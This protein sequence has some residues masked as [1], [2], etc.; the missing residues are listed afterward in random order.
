LATAKLDGMLRGLPFEPAELAWVR[1]R[2]APLVGIESTSSGEREESFTA[3]QRFVEAL[4]GS[5]GA[6]LVFEDLHW[7]DPALLAFLER[8]AGSVTDVPMLLVCSARP[9]LADLHPGWSSDLDNATI[10][11][12][13]PLSAQ[14]TASLVGRLLG[15]S[16]L[17]SDVQ[18]QIVERA[19]NPLYAEELIRMLRDRDLLMERGKSWKLAEGA[20]ILSP[21]ACRGSSRP[22]STL[23]PPITS[24]S[25][26][27]PP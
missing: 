3:W 4:A 25:S 14:E 8:L 2:L 7:A 16:V 18:E 19:G 1:A 27:T 5:G 17:P 23:C 11:P 21:K 22:A 24:V 13:S 10:L 20:P 6:V 9:E 15:T 26:K 12:L